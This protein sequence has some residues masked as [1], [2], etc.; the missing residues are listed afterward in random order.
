[1]NNV[2]A[3]DFYDLVKKEM[4]IIRL[5]AFGLDMDFIDITLHNRG[6]VQL[7]IYSR[8]DGKLFIDNVHQDGFESQLI[9]DGRK[10]LHA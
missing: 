2:T 3:K 6:E 7:D 9:E 8:E 10:E 4:D 1:M 5:A